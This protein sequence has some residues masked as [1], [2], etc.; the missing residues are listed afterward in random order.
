MSIKTI[1]KEILIS[2]AIT[3][4]LSGGIGYAL[5]TYHATSQASIQKSG[6]TNSGMRGNF[7]SRAGGGVASGD[8]VS[9]DNGMLSLKMRDGGSKIIVVASSTKVL[10]TTEGALSEVTPGQTVMIIGKTNGD[11]S[12]TAE[13][14]QL[15]SKD[16]FMP[17]GQ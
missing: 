14:I 9:F 17:R 16:S 1:Q 7:G 12:I 13:S 3:L 4:V 15:R 8:I 11:G 6:I 5:G 10:K 2:I